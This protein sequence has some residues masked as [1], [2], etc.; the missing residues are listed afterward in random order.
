MANKRKRGVHISD[1][2]SKSSYSAEGRKVSTLGSAD[3]DSRG[4]EIEE[5][6]LQ[7][8]LSTIALHFVMMA[9]KERGILTVDAFMDFVRRSGI[10]SAD[11][12]PIFQR[13]FR[14]WLESDFLVF[15]HLAIP[16]M[17]AACLQIAKNARSPIHKEN[18]YGGYNVLLFGD[19]LRSSPLVRTLGRDGVDYFMTL[20][21]DPRGFNLRNEVAHGLRDTNGFDESVANL[22]LVALFHLIASTINKTD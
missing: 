13:A 6:Q 1:L 18:K 10:I 12:Y 11:R 16:Q 19:L 22:V 15:T 20:F 3:S 8:K 21:S 17:E 7:I 14:A 5:L 2:V 9:G 4:Q